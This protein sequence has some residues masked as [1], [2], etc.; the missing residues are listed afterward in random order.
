MYLKEHKNQ[1]YKNILQKYL[2]LQKILKSI[3]GLNIQ[4]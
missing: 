4:K 3:I 1:K 2:K